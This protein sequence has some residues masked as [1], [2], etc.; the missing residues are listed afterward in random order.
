VDFTQEIEVFYS[1]SNNAL[2]VLV[3]DV[4]I[5]CNTSLQGMA[6]MKYGI[7]LGFS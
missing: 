5:A 6:K 3:Q 7:F 4:E 2:I 1:I